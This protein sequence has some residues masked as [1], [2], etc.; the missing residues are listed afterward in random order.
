VTLDQIAIRN[1]NL[2][3][4]IAQIS[5]DGTHGG[6]NCQEKNQKSHHKN[7]LSVSDIPQEVYPPWRAFRCQRLAF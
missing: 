5:A 4:T 2:V 1:I 7:D 6:R 3:I